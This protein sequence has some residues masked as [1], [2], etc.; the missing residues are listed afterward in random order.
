MPRKK[1]IRSVY[2]TKEPDWKTLKLLTD[3]EEREKAFRSCEY[4]VR[5]EIN[6]TKGLPV[7][8]EWIKTH[9][10]WSKEDVKIILANPDWTFSSCITSFYSYH[11][12]GYMPDSLRQHFEKRKVEEWIPKGKKYLKEKKVKIEEKKA[13]P[14]IS[15]QDRMKDQITDLC[16]EFEFY[17]DELVDGNK[18]I[19]DFDPYKMMIAYQPEIKG[20]HAKLIKEE[21]EGQHTEA[22]EVKEWKDDD[23]KEAYGHF[24]VKMRKNFV[25]LFEKINTA[26]DT[27]IKTKASTRKSRKPRARSKESIVKKLKYATNYPD[28]GLASLHPTDIVYANEVWVY[29]TK[30]RKI[31]V[32]Y[33]KNVDPKGLSRPGTGIMVKGTTLQDF[34]EDTSM[35]KTLRKPPEMLKTFDGGKVKCRKSFESLTT[36]PTKLNGRF[37]EHTII[38]RTF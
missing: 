12:L 37:N 3:P 24:D 16:A 6:K 10:G 14:V 21:F 1:Q 4:F 17:I 33:A 30:T 7:V 25:Q 2:V 9:S 23:I 36:T 29:N 13:K 19:K 5:T 20:P 15:I 34:N 28:L 26:C 32:Y 31:G 8:K 38:L 27:I 22:L 35:Q 11:K 18:T